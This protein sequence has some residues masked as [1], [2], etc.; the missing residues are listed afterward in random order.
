MKNVKNIKKQKKRRKSKYLIDKYPCNPMCL[1]QSQDLVSPFFCFAHFILLKFPETLSKK[2]GC[3][4]S[5]A[6]TKSTLTP[7]IKPIA[8]DTVIP[9]I[10]QSK[11]N[12][13]AFEISLDDLVSNPIGKRNSLPKLL[14]PIDIQ[15]KLA[16]SEAR[17]KEI[18]KRKKGEKP[19]STYPAEKDLQAIKIKLLQKEAAAFANREKEIKKIQQKLAKQEAHARKVLERKKT[20]GMGNEEMRLSWGGENGLAGEMFK[21]EVLARDSSDATTGTLINE[22]Y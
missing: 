17:W 21:K 7:T 10:K 1:D 11:K 4:A 18:E 20:N 5:N 22:V 15:Q 12:A 2:M 9:A 19:I 16:N 14:S 6:S 3:A 13:I 8:Y